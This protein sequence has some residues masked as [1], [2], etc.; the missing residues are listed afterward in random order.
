MKHFNQESSNLSNLRLDGSNNLAMRIFYRLAYKA[1]YNEIIRSPNLFEPNH[2]SIL[3]RIAADLNQQFQKLG[4]YFIEE[5]SPADLQMSEL[6]RLVEQN[7][8]TSDELQQFLD[9]KGIERREARE[10]QR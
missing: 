8:I 7:K 4:E 1:T 10:T 3:E 5:V 9:S 6:E 2:R